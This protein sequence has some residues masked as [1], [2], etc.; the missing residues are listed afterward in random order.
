[1]VADRTHRTWYYMQQ[2]RRT[3]LGNPYKVSRMNPSYVHGKGHVNELTGEHVDGLSGSR[4]VPM[5]GVAGGGF[6]FDTNALHKAEH[7]G[8]ASRTALVLEFHAHG[9]VGALMDAGSPGP[10]PSIQSNNSKSGVPG[11]L[12]FPEETVFKSSQPPGSQ[13]SQTSQTATVSATRGGL[14]VAPGSGL[15]SAFLLVQPD[16]TYLFNN[17]SLF[18]RRFVYQGGESL[19]QNWERLHVSELK[20][21]TATK[22]IVMEYFPKGEYRNFT[23]KMLAELPRSIAKVAICSIWSMSPPSRVGLWGLQ[24]SLIDAAFSYVQPKVLAAKMGAQR[25]PYHIPWQK[26]NFLPHTYSMLSS[27]EL[28]QLARKKMDS[29]SAC[30]TIISTGD[31]FRNHSHSI[32]AAQNLGLHVLVVTSSSSQSCCPPEARMFCTCV[33]L[34]RGEYL[35]RLEDPRYCAVVVPL[36]GHSPSKLGLGLTSVTEAISRVVPVVTMNYNHFGGYLVQGC[37]AHLVGDQ[38]GYSY[39]EAVQRVIAGRNVSCE[40]EH[41]LNTFTL[42]SASGTYMKSLSRM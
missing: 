14:D 22:W 37:N 20:T 12:L 42:E 16:T 34:T 25:S 6:I 35:T 27:S 32:V 13:T 31:T 8:N 18:S 36:D 17:P 39:T 9:K 1:V 24:P 15:G 38:L 29:T 21:S 41:A 4:L 19:A 2:G 30:D 3:K 33:A 28:T 7:E 26:L 10:C 5:L 40:L 11:F 23:E